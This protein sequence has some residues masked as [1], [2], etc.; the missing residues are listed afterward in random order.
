[1]VGHHRSKS[2]FGEVAVADH[3]PAVRVRFRVRVSVRVR[4]KDRVRVYGKGEG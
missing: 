1:V 4:V 3:T 2:S